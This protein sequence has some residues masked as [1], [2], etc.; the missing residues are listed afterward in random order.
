MKTTN[1]NTMRMMGL[2]GLMGLMAPTVLAQGDVKDKAAITGSNVSAAN[3][4]LMVL[5]ASEAAAGRAGMKLLRFTEAVN[6]PSFFSAVP[7]G[8]FSIGKTTGLQAA[9]DG[10]QAGLVSGTTLKTINSTSLLG[11]GNLAIDATINNADV[12]NAIAEARATTR[13][14]LT[15]ETHLFASDFGVVGDGVADDTAELQAAIVA[16]TA[17]KRTLVVRGTIKLSDEIVITGAGTKIDGYGATLVQSNAAK[18]GLKFTPPVSGVIIEGLTVSGQGPASHDAVGLHLRK[19]DLSYIGPD[20]TFREV[21]IH[22]FRRG[23]RIANVTTLNM[24]AVTVYNARIGHDWYLVQTGVAQRLRVVQGE[25]TAGTPHSDSCCFKLEGTSYGLEINGSEFGGYNKFVLATGMHAS[26]DNCNVESISSG[27]IFDAPYG[28]FLSFTN[29]K[30]QQT[31]TALG[32]IVSYNADNG[33]L[34]L[35]WH[36]NLTT[37]AVNACEVEVYGSS[38]IR[39]P[40][41]TGKDLLIAYATTQGGARTTIRQQAPTVQRNVAA[42]VLPGDGTVFPGASAIISSPTDVAPDTWADNPLIRYKNNRTGA[43][44]WGSTSNNMLSRV[45]AISDNLAN[46]TTTERDFIG[47]QGTGFTLPAGTLAGWGESLH[48][49]LSGKTAAHASNGRTFKVYYGGTLRQTFGPF[50]TTSAES[51]RLEVDVQKYYSG[52]SGGVIISSALIGGAGIGYNT[53]SDIVA[54]STSLSPVATRV[55]ATGVESGD[56]VLHAGKMTWWRTTQGF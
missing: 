21:T 52:N 39:G 3:D 46:T 54:F 26:F 9:L 5:D 4:S 6:V 22:G 53:Q 44:E 18:N 45:L 33:G 48:C 34:S 47:T 14:A 2:I 10:K 16:A 37:L 40:V 19:D 23:T 42:G 32:A 49:K 27:I 24:D 13:A 55:T 56:I 15:P 38:Y 50:T 29:S 41:T 1:K 28:G 17:A 12:N 7:D 35:N 25:N 31:I 8:T 51:F 36:N 11:S 30:I 20:Y 43:N